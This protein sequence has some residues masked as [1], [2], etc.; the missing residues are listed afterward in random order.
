[1][2]DI[3]ANF[4]AVVAFRPKDYVSPTWNRAREAARDVLSRYLLADGRDVKESML[5]LSLIATEEKKRQYRAKKAKAKGEAIPSPTPVTNLHTASARKELWSACYNSLASDDPHGLAILVKAISS[6]S[7]VEKL[8][9]HGTW[10][11]KDLGLEQVIKEHDFVHA[12]RAINSVIVIS[13]DQFTRAL[14]SLAMQP[15]PGIVMRIWSEP[16]FPQ[17]AVILLLSPI[18]EVHDP[19]ISLIQQSFDNVDDRG[20]CFRTVLSKYPAQAMD[21]LCTFLS[22]FVETAR[23]TPES[24]SLAKWLVRCFTDILDTLCQSSDEDGPLLH[25][26]AFLSTFAGGTPMSKR[27]A[28]LWHLMTTALAVIFKRTIDWAPLY[29]NETMVDWMRDALIFARGMAEHIRAFESAALGIPGARRVTDGGESP[30]K[31]TKTG[32]KLVSKL[33]N[34]LRD[35]VSWLRLTEWVTKMLCRGLQLT[36]ASRRCIRPL[37]S[38]RPS[39]AALPDRPLTC[40]KHPSSN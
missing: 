33:E 11:H 5:G 21:G 2:I 9:R 7:H 26:T 36:T 31:Q 3:H 12:V 29:D 19:T 10:N 1:V 17:S 32:A 38:S 28:T 25:S 40:R 22:D 30:A 34:V 6:F 14:E 39:S 15:D 23:V 18:E 13:R 16:D 24:C 4:I 20:D 37:S 8:D 35:L 27:V